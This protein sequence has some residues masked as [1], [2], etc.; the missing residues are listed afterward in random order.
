MGRSVR[1]LP[2]MRWTRGRTLAGLAGIVLVACYFLSLH[3]Q[4]QRDALMQADP[5]TILSTPFLLSAAMTLGKPVFARH[6]AGCHGV[7]GK[8]DPS[9]GAPDLTDGKV[10][11]GTGRVADIEQI[12]LYG[13]RSG[14]PRGWKLASMPAFGTPRPYGAEPIPPLTPGDIDDVVEH[15]MA[16]RGHAVDKAAAVRGAAIFAGRGACWDCHASDGMGD[17][18]I[19]A[20][21]LADD[22]RLFGDGSRASLWR[23]IA[24]GYAGVSPAFVHSLSPVE[25]RA[26][27]AY[28]A[29]LTTPLTKDVR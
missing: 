11:F 9:K 13:I 6:C 21:N 25:A 27:S 4:R 12:T 2:A 29:A 20:P 8:G 15:L 16:L 7:E 5:E 28:V 19:G 22:I 18:S 24:R 3:R 26:V 23:V 17:S 14:N 10:L 1:I